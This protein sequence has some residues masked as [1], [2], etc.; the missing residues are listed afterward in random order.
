[1]TTGTRPSK[2]VTGGGASFKTKHVKISSMHRCALQV[3]NIPEIAEGPALNKNYL[4]SPLPVNF[5]PAN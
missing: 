2:P 3:N 5:V 4:G 1:M